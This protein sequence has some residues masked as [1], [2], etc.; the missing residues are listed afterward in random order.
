MAASRTS[1]ERQSPALRRNEW[2]D[3]DLAA[4]AFRPAILIPAYEKCVPESE[5]NLGKTAAVG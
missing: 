2:D 1:I 5:R 4:D 3:P